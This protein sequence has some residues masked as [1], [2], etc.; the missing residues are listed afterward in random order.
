MPVSEG[1]TQLLQ[2][3]ECGH[4][5]LSVTLHLTHWSE[6]K[7]R[8][9]CCPPYRTRTACPQSPSPAAAV[10]PGAALPIITLLLLLLCIVVLIG[11]S[12]SRQGVS[13]QRLQQGLHLL[14]E[15]HGAVWRG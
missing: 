8:R 9:L 11:L 7:R 14:P 15:R 3:G 5:H 13:L 2:G 1:S 12:L 6:G 4:S 10:Q